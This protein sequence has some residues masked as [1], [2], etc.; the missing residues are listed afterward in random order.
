[1]LEVR[2]KKEI[3]NE[4]RTQTGVE[5]SNKT[6][7]RSLRERNQRSHMLVRKTGSHV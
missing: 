3:A 4:L 5:V 7:Q 6:I 2:S 1:M